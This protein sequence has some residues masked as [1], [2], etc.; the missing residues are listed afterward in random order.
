MA[1]QETLQ[2][3]KRDVKGT[4]ASKRLR[5]TGVVPAVIYGSNQREYTI[6]LD[7]K[8]FFDLAR[9]QASHNFLVNIEI[10]GAN[11]KTKLAIV[12]DIQRDPLN[13]S[14]IH[15]DFRAV[16]ES[17]TIHAAVPIELRGEPVGVKTGG[18]LEQLVHEIEV[19]CS[20]SNLPDAIVNDVESLKIGQS[21]KVSQLNLPEGVTVKLDGEVLVALITQTRASISEGTGGAEEVVE[22]APAA[23]ADEAAGEAEASEEA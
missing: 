2:A 11:E 3:E 21:L 20:P 10:A 14:L 8:S 19:S 4:T 1:K 17:D 23:E 9:K 16:S 15:V 5:R 18:L 22:E 13:G 7:S 6:Q 12:Q